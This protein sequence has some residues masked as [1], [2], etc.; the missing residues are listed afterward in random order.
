MTNINIW[1]SRMLKQSASATCYVYGVWR[2]MCE[3]PRFSHVKWLFRSL[4]GPVSIKP[5]GVL[6]FPS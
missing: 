6:R 4:L 1:P 2:E 3:Q 5:D